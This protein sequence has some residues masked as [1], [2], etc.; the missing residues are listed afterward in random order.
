MLYILTGADDYSLRQELAR[1][2]ADI[3]DESM[4]DANCTVCDGRQVSPDELAAQ[5]AA[6]PFLAERRLVI[7][8]GL[9]SRLS[10]GGRKKAASKAAPKAGREAGQT[11]RFLSVFSGL[12]E[13]TVMVLVEGDLKPANALLKRLGTAATVRQ[14]PRLKPGE[15]VSWVKRRVSAAGGTITD[16]AAASLA[17]TVGNNLWV[18]N[19]EIEKLVLYAAGRPISE[20]DLA[21]LVGSAR[22]ASI[23]ALVD[24]VLAPSPA[25]AQRLL[26]ARLREGDSAT[27]VTYQLHRQ[28]QMI[29][30]VREMKRRRAPRSEMMRQLGIYQDWLVA[31]LEEQAARYPLTRL[32]AAYRRLRDTERAIKTGRYDGELALNILIAELGVD[33]PGQFDRK[34]PSRVN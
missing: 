27:T 31:K 15:L 25:L 26:T 22:E 28:L 32:R 13:T 11:E 1:L 21:Q 24:A 20:D 23:F 10:G 9:L 12:P 34:R 2:K 18:M 30:R 33:T 3:G 4:R 6:A 7:V 14:F 16:A 29:V 5:A 17:R 19:G 8:E